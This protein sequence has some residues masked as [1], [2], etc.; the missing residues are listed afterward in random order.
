MQF[1]LKQADIYF[2]DGYTKTGKVNLMAGYAAALTTIAVDGITGQIPVG[3]SF[4]IDSDSTGTGYTVTATSE[5]LGNTTSLTFTP[6]L[7]ESIANDDNLTFGGRRLKAKVG[8]G[9]MS[10]DEKRPIEYKKDRGKLD[11]V[12]LGDEEP[13]EVKLDLRWEFLKSDS[14]DPT[15]IPSIEEVLKQTGAASDWTTS[16][17][18]P[19]EPYAVNIYVIFAPPCE[20][21]KLETILL[22]DFR[23]EQLSHDFKQG[24]IATSG[25]CNVTQ[26]EATRVAQS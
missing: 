22:R 15:S 14:A 11:T 19:C 9:T 12:R 25:K 5:T 16:A 2:V 10:Y 17:S 24:M 3:V 13:I 21:V 6:G 26:A 8:D 20:S 7:A 18:D 23:Y 1:D 4:S